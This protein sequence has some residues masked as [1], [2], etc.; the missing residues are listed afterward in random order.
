MGQTWLPIGRPRG[1][2]PNFAALA[3]SS[4]VVL[5]PIATRFMNSRLD[6]SL[7]IIHLLLQLYSFRPG[8]FEAILIQALQKSRRSQE[9][10]YQCRDLWK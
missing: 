1:F 2:A 9:I 8:D 4:P 3:A 6:I 10:F 7:I 5:E